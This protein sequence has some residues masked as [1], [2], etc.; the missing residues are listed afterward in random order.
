[1]R[2]CLFASIVSAQGIP[3]GDFVRKRIKTMK[4][5]KAAKIILVSSVA[6]LGGG[7]TAHSQL[8]T[9]AAGFGGRRLAIGQGTSRQRAEEEAA[10]LALAA[11]RGASTEP[12]AEEGG[13]SE[14][15]T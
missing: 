14:G 11:L 8:F 3:L 6:I 10:A 2:F 7:I 1:M 13:A 5:A 15:P 12:V 9:V 4:Y